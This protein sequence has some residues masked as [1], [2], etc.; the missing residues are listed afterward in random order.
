[1]V[2][3]PPRSTLFPYTTLFRSRAHGRCGEPLPEGRNVGSRRFRF[4]NRLDRPD[5]YLPLVIHGEQLVSPLTEHRCSRLFDPTWRDVFPA[6]DTPECQP[7]WLPVVRMER[8]D[9]ERSIPAPGN[10]GHLVCRSLELLAGRKLVV[11]AGLQNENGALPFFAHRDAGCARVERSAEYPTRGRKQQLR[12]SNPPQPHCAILAGCRNLARIRV[13]DGTG[14]R[15]PMTTEHRDWRPG[16][17]RPDPGR[18]VRACRDKEF[19]VVGRVRIHDPIVVRPHP[20]RVGRRIDPEPRGLVGYRKQ[21]CCI[22]MP[23]GKLRAKHRTLVR[24]YPALRLVL[25]VALETSELRVE[26]PDGRLVVL[27]R[28]HDEGA[29]VRVKPYI[30]DGRI[31]LDWRVLDAEAGCAWSRPEVPDSDDTGDIACCE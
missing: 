8:P 23:D 20:P 30:V 7:R 3:R 9:Q 1:M 6:F 17:R 21:R 14:Q 25:L 11:R 4:S 15:I 28:G 10:A 27:S 26:M 16:S 18:P 13:D 12:R 2:R 22:V 31:V 24:E 19:A 29:V 5:G